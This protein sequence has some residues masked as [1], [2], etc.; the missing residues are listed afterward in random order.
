M[1]EGPL[2]VTPAAREDKDDSAT[3][4]DDDVPAVPPRPSEPVQPSSPVHDGYSLQY[5]IGSYTARSLPDD[6]FSGGT[7]EESLPSAVKDFFDMVGSSEGSYPSGFP[8]SLRG[9]WSCDATQVE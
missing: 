9:K 4:S 3:E 6:G 2:P 5:E 1:F 8:E 7:S